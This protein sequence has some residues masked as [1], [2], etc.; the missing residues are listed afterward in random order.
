MSNGHSTI[1]VISREKAKGRVAQTKE[2]EQLRQLRSQ[3]VESR[4]LGGINGAESKRDLTDRLVVMVRDPYWLHAYWEL[5]PRTVERAQ[6]ALGQNWHGT[7]PVFA[8]ISRCGRRRGRT[9]SRDFDPW[10]R[11]SLVCRC[12]E[13]TAKVSDGDWLPDRWRP[14]LLPG[15]QQ[16]REHA[17]GWHERFGRR[18]LGRHRPERG[19]HIRDERRLLR[20]RNEP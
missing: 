7:R 15:S 19:P 16:Y 6:S 4:Q 9:A 3:I 10:R 17:A 8:R 14:V 20:P 12:A 13:P 18:K 5:N 1:S 11:E 2:L